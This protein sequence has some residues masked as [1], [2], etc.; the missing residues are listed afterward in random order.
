[1]RGKNNWKFDDVV[2]VLLANGFV[3]ATS[4]HQKATSH[5]YYTRE[6]GKKA[7]LVH[8]QYHVGRSLPPKTMETIIN[9]SGLPSDYWM[10][11]SKL[12][13]RTIKKAPYLVES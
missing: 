10:R 2:T 1:M 8:V 9:T 12:S 5:H 13:K 11:V 7:Y 6:V 4:H 3:E